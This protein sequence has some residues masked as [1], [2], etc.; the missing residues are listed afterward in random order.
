MKSCGNCIHSRLAASSMQVRSGTEPRRPLR[1]TCHLFPP[2]PVPGPQGLSFMF[3]IV[4]DTSLCGQ[5]VP[6]PG[7]DENGEPE[8]EDKPRLMMS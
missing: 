8:G 1:L 2:V 3:P 5:W 6:R 4:M 7:F